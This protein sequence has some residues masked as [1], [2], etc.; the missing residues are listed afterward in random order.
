M[1]FTQDLEKSAVDK[2]SNSNPFILLDVSE[3]M[4]RSWS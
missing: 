3:F 4:G 2:I 1:L